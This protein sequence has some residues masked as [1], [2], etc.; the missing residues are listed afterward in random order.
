LNNVVLVGFMGSGKTT[1][2]R[3][4]AAE[5][6]RPF[7]DLDDQIVTDAGR[8]VEQIFADEGE[9]GFRDREARA[10]QRAL[11]RDGQVVA[12]GGGAPLR[13]ENWTRMRAGNCVVALTAEPGE[14]IRRLNGSRER[15]LLGNDVATAIDSLLPRRMPRYREADL[16]VATDAAVPHDIAQQ[17]AARLP[18]AGVDRI[19]I[20]IPG[21]PHEVT[22]GT[23][24]QNLVAA[25]LQRMATSGA[26]MVVSDANVAERHGP[27]VHAA[28]RG[29]GFPSR[30]H[31][32]PI[33]EAAKEMAV[34]SGI[35]EAM[36]AA[37]VDR[38]G[39]LIALGGGAVGDVAGFAAATWMRGIRYLQLPTTLLA[40]V[41]SS[42]GGKTAI[43]LPSGKNLVGA[44]HQ[45]AAIFCDL[46][47]LS[48]L[49]DDEYRA[50]LAE[51]IKAAVIA[52]RAFFDWLS[53]NMTA[54]LGRE[55]AIIRESV[56]RAIGIKAA[57]VADDPTETGRRAILNYGH[58][59]GHALE[60]VAGYG[61]L[62][63]GQAVAWGMQVAARVSL[64]SGRCSPSAVEA[65]QSLLQ[66]GGLLAAPPAVR[67]A[68]LVEAMRHDKKARSGEP[69][70]VLLKEIGQVEYGQPVEVSI[71]RAALTEVLKP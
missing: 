38:D 66:D 47:Y 1:V 12:A 44:V 20:D 55:P 9:A 18:D 2:G 57:V 56:R 69:R 60:R 70:W 16:L 19:P 23:R 6:G 67:G 41:D 22:L 27:S 42:I 13:D 15:P 63:H 54:L 62:R 31:I 32:L 34:L 30:L 48:T 33:G 45:P 58:T 68:D 35:Y 24:L 8:S 10:L 51:V 36:A 29:A 64:L 40:M 46:D 7:I 5:T 28:L 14:L 37:G 65:Q 21:S 53:M 4:L 61:R 26:V 49:P 25:A 71:V 39:A 52:D 3:A 17:I 50:A 11:E 59:I 43:N